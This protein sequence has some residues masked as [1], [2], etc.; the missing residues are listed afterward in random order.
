VAAPFLTASLVD[1]LL[2]YLPDGS[3]S[4]KPKSDLAGTFMPPGFAITGAC[5]SGSFIRIDAL[6]DT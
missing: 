1:R 2:V 3:A 6:P 5:K 4:A